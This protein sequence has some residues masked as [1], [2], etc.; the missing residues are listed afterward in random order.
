MQRR[1]LLQRSEHVGHVQQPFVA[2]DGGVV[3]HGKGATRLQGL[4][5]K[6]VAVEALPAQGEEEGALG[7]VTRVGG[8]DAMR[9]E[10]AVKL[11]ERSIGYL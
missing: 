9:L 8:D 1:E 7:A 11:L 10:Q 4:L 5:G 3:Y 6:G 2:P